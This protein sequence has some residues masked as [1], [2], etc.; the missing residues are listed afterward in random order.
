MYNAS[1]HLIFIIP[2]DVHYTIIKGSDDVSSSTYAFF[3]L[4]KELGH[5]SVLWKHLCAAGIGLCTVCHQCFEVFL[6]RFFTVWTARWTSSFACGYRGLVRMRGNPVFWKMRL[7]KIATHCQRWIVQGYQV[8]Q[9]L[10]EGVLSHQRSIMW[11]FCHLYIMRK[12]VYDKQVGMT[13]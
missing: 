2:T 10:T 3:V 6:S 8:L 13:S 11:K 9:T 4:Q 1:L 12:I 5:F 7:M